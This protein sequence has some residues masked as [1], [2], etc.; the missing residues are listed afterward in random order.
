MN[1]RKM[2]CLLGVIAATQTIGCGGGAP[3]GPLL[4]KAKGKVNY[5]GKPLSGATVTFAYEEKGPICNGFTNAEGEFRITTGGRAGARIGD[6]KVVIVKASTA[7]RP[8]D[9]KPE[10]MAKMAVEGGY[11][12]ED[13][14]KP[15]IPDKYSNPGTSGLTAAVVADAS[16]NIFE[17]NLVD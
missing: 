8:K 4:V 3:T 15:E 13:M 6:A 12:P 7:N 14:P 11:R 9:P 2:I 16:K 17:F 10:D 5:N 1:F